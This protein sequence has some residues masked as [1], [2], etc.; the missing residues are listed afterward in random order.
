[1]TTQTSLF[2]VVPAD[3]T[4]ERPGRVHRDDPATSHGAAS[5][6]RRLAGQRLAVFVAL[7]AA[8]ER[9]LTPHEACDV[10]PCTY[11]HVCATRMAELR[12]LELCECTPSTRP[13]PAGA[14]AHVWR[15]TAD[16]RRVARELAQ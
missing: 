1:M 11:P 13:T 8:G 16:G 4:A 6:V 9:G 15:L 10:T 12:D 14:N 3:V 2:D 5:G 7:A